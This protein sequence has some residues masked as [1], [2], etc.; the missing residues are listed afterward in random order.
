[1]LPEDNISKLIQNHKR[2]LQ[3]LKEQQAIFGFNTLPAILIEIE[4]IEA[5]IKN[6]ELQKT[7]LDGSNATAQ[8]AFVEFN[9]QIEAYLDK[10][11]D[12]HK[13]LE[14]WKNVHNT[15]QDIQ[16]YFALCRIYIPK[17]N[18]SIQERIFFDV[19][20][21]WR[22]CNR[23]LSK[24]QQWAVNILQ[25]QRE[26]DEVHTIVGQSNGLDDNSSSSQVLRIWEIAIKINKALNE[27]NPMTLPEYLSDFGDQVDQLLFRADKKL[28]EVVDAIN[29]LP[30]PS[31]VQ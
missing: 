24:L 29:H 6:L 2:R 10:F 8:R 1:M 9:R 7:I 11:N 14:A 3:I 5:K 13:Q 15:L 27:S 31:F 19:E 28:L 22:P 12:L 17:F 30:R 26:M 18:G 21:Q 23:S 25:L 16:F 20:A 4:D